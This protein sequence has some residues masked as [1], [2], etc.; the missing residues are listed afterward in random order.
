MT[1]SSTHRIACRR[2]PTT[3][4]Y[5][6]FE[7][8]IL[9]AS[10]AGTESSDVVSINIMPD[11]SLELTINSDSYTVASPEEID[12]DGLG[13]NDTLSITRPDGV[14]AV[15]EDGAFNIDG[16]RFNL[17]DFE[18]VDDVP[19]GFTIRGTGADDVLTTYP[20]ITPLLNDSTFGLPKF[21]TSIAV[22]FDGDAG[23]DQVI[24]EGGDFITSGSNENIS[25][26]NT[27]EVLLN[28]FSTDYTESQVAGTDGDDVV[29]V[30]PSGTDIV[31]TP[32]TGP[33]ITFTGAYLGGI[34]LRFLDSA[35]N[36]SASID[37][38]GDSEIF[39]GTPESSRYSYGGAGGNIDVT[40]DG[41]ESVNVIASGGTQF[42]TSTATISATDGNE[43]LVYQTGEFSSSLEVSGESWSIK[44]ENFEQTNVDLG[45]G[46][47]RIESDTDVHLS[48][49]DGLKI[50]TPFRHNYSYVGAGSLEIVGDTPHRIINL[51][52]NA[53]LE[54]D[55]STSPFALRSANYE[56]VEILNNEGFQ[57]HGQTDTDERI[58]VVAPVSEDAR[59]TFNDFSSANGVATWSNI[60][61][62]SIEGHN[63]DSEVT[64]EGTDGA[65]RLIFNGTEA[66]FES[67]G[68]SLSARQFGSVNVIAGEGEDA[69]FLRGASDGGNTFVGNSTSAVLTTP[70]ASITATGFDLVGAV[71]GGV[72]DQATFIGTAEAEQFYANPTESRMVG[73]GFVLNASG[74]EEVLAEGGQGDFANVTDSAGNDSFMARPGLATVAFSE[75]SSVTM[76]A[77]TTVRSVSSAG[78]DEAVFEGSAGSERFVSQADR[79]GRLSGTNFSFI[80]V[81]YPSVLADG[82]D[83]NDVAY[84]TD[85]EGDDSFVASREL[86][87]LSG[88]GFSNS[89]RG[90]D[91]VYGYTTEGND[92]AEIRGSESDESFYANPLVAL[93]TGSDFQAFVGGFDVVR[94]IGGGG[95]DVATLRDS[96][97]DDSFTSSPAFASLQGIGFRNQVEGFSRVKA[98]SVAGM[99]RA[100]FEGSIAADNFVGNRGFSYLEGSGYRNQANGFEDV[101]VVGLSGLDTASLFDSEEDEAFIGRGNLATLSGDTFVIQLTDFE[102]VSVFGFN[103]GTNSFTVDNPDFVWERL[104]NW[105]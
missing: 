70:L 9:L 12:I 92:V 83:G 1:R 99:D 102:S 33:T 80:A 53:E 31:W 96:D 25:W 43:S 48:F 95:D 105:S 103:G 6:C 41:F 66:F 62:I 90:F 36:D 89:V 7:S 57:V 11:S 85:S 73:S 60:N 101:S 54:V 20:G 18:L 93:L 24:T 13:G 45:G 59:L 91:E 19:G 23:H 63:D 50:E 79:F 51:D 68:T 32:S 3:A 28:S 81:A 37:D 100:V 64:L 21:D 35:G 38:Y 4:S 15:F 8:R 52:D 76:N 78:A 84:L 65:D 42:N 77:F 94:A 2:Q 16:F 55:F 40:F 14:D 26:I 5:E 44:V 10:F 61:I 39:T 98:I 56:G 104:G 72:G 69:A 75:G 30:D 29:N 88:D 34:F 87:S 17:V 82:A 71:A 27:E 74:F 46:L 67:A 86:S 58:H 47:D 49:D 22:E 97:G